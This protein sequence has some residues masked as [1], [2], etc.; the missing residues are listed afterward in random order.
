MKR[1][2]KFRTPIFY[3]DGKFAR[4]HYWGFIKDGFISPINLN[5]KVKDKDNYQFTG[6]TDKKRTKE[7][8]NGQEIYEGDILSGKNEGVPA[9]V[10]WNISGAG[11]ELKWGDKEESY[12][13]THRTY[14]A[15]EVIGNIH[16]NP[17]LLK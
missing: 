14:N 1:E 8:P 13:Y 15:L 10:V 16:E 7:F 6:L 12:G 11:F 9:L 5:N 3:A 2:I 4:F 17:E